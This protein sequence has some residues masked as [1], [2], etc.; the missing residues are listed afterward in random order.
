MR[1]GRILD[2]STSV[3][4]VEVVKGWALFWKFLKDSSV[5]TQK[6]IVIK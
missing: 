5:I 1:N 6:I 3:D 2:T 4:I